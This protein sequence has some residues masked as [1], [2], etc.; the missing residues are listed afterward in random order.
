MYSTVMTPRRA[1]AL[2]FIRNF[3]RIRGQ[4]PTVREIQNHFR[5]ASPNA[6]Q[7]IVT[8]LREAGYLRAD[9]GG[10]RAIVPTELEAGISVYGTIPAGIPI[11]ALDESD[12]VLAVDAAVFGA[13][14]GERVFALRV[15]GT[16]MIR[17]GILE[18]DLAVLAVRPVANGDVVAALVDG[19]STLKRYVVSRGKVVLRPEGPGYRD[20]EPATELLIQGVMVGLIRRRL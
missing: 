10:A 16:S 3:V 1:Q 2:E 11:D 17:A 14:P 9:L 5:F 13:R 6:A 4:G 20:I 19:R 7:E 15:R 18:G 12:E 8:K